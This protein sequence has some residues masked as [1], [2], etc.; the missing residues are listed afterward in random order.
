M[1]DILT[2]GELLIDFTPVKAEGCTGALCP[3]P[4]GAPANVAVQLSRLGISTGFIG[5]VG[6]DNFGITL[7]KCLEQNHVDTE[8]LIEDDDF[9]TTLAFVQLDEN[10]DRSFTFYRNPGADT[11]LRSEEINMEPI[12]KCS[13]L[14]FGSLSLTTEPGKTTTLELVKAAKAMGKCISYDP[15]WRPALWKSET[16]GIAAMKLGLELCDILKISQEELALLTETDSIREGTKKL[17]DLGIILIIVTLGPAGCVFSYNG[18][19]NHQPTFDTKVVDTTGSGDSFW[20]AF[21]YQLYAHGYHTAET[22]KNLSAG[23]L[24]EFCT[25]ANGAGSIC[26][27]RPGGIPALADEKGILDCIESYPLLQTNFQLN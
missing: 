17:H 26:A 15:N 3:N 25:F 27:S 22:L 21:L 14:H 23:Q 24:K 12:K 16:E 19:L 11:Q 13:I 18:E 2:T 8:N 1:P 20:G 7:R 9:R 4:G 10:G 6:K 5:K